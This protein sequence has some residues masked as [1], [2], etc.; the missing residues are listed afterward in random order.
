MLCSYTVQRIWV[1]EANQCLCKD[2]MHHDWRFKC[3]SGYPLIYE[4]CNSVLKRTYYT[5]TNTHT[6]ARFFMKSLM[7][8]ICCECHNGVKFFLV[9]LIWFFIHFIIPFGNFRLPHLG[10]TTAAARAALT[11]LQ[12]ACWV[13]SCFRNPL[14]SDMDYIRT[15][16]FLCVRVHTGGWAHRQRVSTTFLTQKN[17]QIF[18]MLLTQTG[19]KSLVLG[20]WVRRSTNWATP[21]IWWWDPRWEIDTLFNFYS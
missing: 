17:W 19:F 13:F 16:S 18:L 2:N 1:S 6:R 15:W 14:N 3:T 12:S 11:R 5:N 21:Y 10:K 9:F 4:I 20:S 7:T 8:A